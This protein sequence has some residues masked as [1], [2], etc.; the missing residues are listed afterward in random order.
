MDY[1]EKQMDEE[2]IGLPTPNNAIF[3]EIP[4]LLAEKR[5]ALAAVRT[6]NAVFAL[7]SLGAER[8]DRDLTVLQY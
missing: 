3:G 4:V 6:G 8:A 2:T 1:I 7:A 5:T